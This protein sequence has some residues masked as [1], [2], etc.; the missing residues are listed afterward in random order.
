MRF[1]FINFQTMEVPEVWTICSLNIFWFLMSCVSYLCFLIKYHKFCGLKQ[2]PD[3]LDSRGSAGSSA[4]DLHEASVKT[5]ARAA[6]SSEAQGRLPSLP[7]MGNCNFLEVVEP[8]PSA[9]GDHPLFHGSLHSTAVCCFKVKKS[10][11]YFFLSFT[12]SASFKGFT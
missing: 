9:F 4:Q 12:S 3:S 11:Y 7:V 8:R 2:D 10:V 6:I 5:A 1:M